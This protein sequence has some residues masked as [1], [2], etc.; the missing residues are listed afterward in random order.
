ML[1]KLISSLAP[2]VKLDLVSKRPKVLANLAASMQVLRADKE[3][4]EPDIISS[5]ELTE[6][7]SAFGCRF[8]VDI[9]QRKHLFSKSSP[10]YFDTK[11]VYTFEQYDNT[12]DFWSY[13]LNIAMFNF[14]LT[15]I[16]NGQPFQFNAMK[17][18]D[19]KYLWLF[20]LWNDRLIS[21]STS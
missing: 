2:G 19:G 7:S 21:S 1:K 20:Q 13:T 5:G 16:V 17:K 10:E 12:F 9:K 3:G 4:S 6:S 15:K 8:G 18:S 14:D 11:T